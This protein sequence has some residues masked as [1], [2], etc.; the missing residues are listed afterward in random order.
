LKGP[1]IDPRN[2][3]LA[4]AVITLKFFH[5]SILAIKDY[6]LL[7]FSEAEKI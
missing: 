7:E 1:G 3:L 6:P 4:D 2:R 5:P